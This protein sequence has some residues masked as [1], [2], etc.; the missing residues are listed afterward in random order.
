[1]KTDWL[2]QVIQHLERTGGTAVLDS[3]AVNS[4]DVFVALPGQNVDGRDF[5]SQVL[6]QES[7]L[8]LAE[9]EAGR[10]N[11]GTGGE[12]SVVWVPELS[13]RLGQLA[14][15]LFAVN[16]SNLSLLGVTG[17]NG[18]T[19]ISHFLAQ[20]LSAEAGRCGL[21]GTIGAGL[22]PQQQTT[23]NTTPDV[24]TNHRLLAQWAEMNVPYAAMEVSSHAL[25][26]GRVDG[27]RFRVAMFTQLTRDHLDFHGTMEN[28]FAA[29]KQLFDPARSQAAV[30]CIDD[31]WGQELLNYRRDAIRVSGKVGA[32]A[33]VAPTQVER[34]P[35]GLRI[36]WTTPWGDGVT[37]TQL[38]GDFNVANLAVVIGTLGAL[39]LSF[40]RMAELLAQLTPVAGR[41]QPVLLKNGVLA[42][43]DYA[44]TPDA[45]EKA[46]QAARHHSTGRVHCVFGCGGERDRGKRPLMAAAAAARADQL[47]VT[48]D[49]PRSE[50]FL[51][52]VSD[53]LPGMPRDARYEVVADRAEAILMAVRDAV[54]G[55]V[56]LIA[57]KGHETYQEI[58]GVKHHYSDLEAVQA[59]EER[60]Q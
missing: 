59:A 2:T 52:I 4:G 9:G 30:V 15:A 47:W 60:A 54:P 29:K 43:V 31:R 50:S 38:I 19:S 7:V 25:V 11:S 44:H 32:V 58:Q 34:H 37:D 23:Y 3:R 46:L 5:I 8:V 40:E 48:S 51:Q 56:I 13:R 21:I 22:W 17:T 14:E 16:E 42:L 53:M 33:N 41:M 49:N 36:S 18:K 55:D 12:H 39:G 20:C 57:G 28:Y 24:L 10:Q 27:L 35:Q 6:G 26:Q 45:L 1:M